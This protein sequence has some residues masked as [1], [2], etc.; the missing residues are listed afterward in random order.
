M[1]VCWM[2]SL[3]NLMFSCQDIY[4]AT[5]TIKTPLILSMNTLE[6]TPKYLYLI[7]LLT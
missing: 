1:K 7:N 3:F 6:S 4:S 2:P 5:D